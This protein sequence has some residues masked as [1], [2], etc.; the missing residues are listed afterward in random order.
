MARPRKKERKLVSSKPCI[1]SEDGK[2]RIFRCRKSK[3]HCRIAPS[4]SCFVHICPVTFNF[5]SCRE[6]T[7]H[8]FLVSIFHSDA[9]HRLHLLSRNTK[10]IFFDIVSNCF[11]S[12][13]NGI[14]ITSSNKLVVCMSLHLLNLDFQEYLSTMNGLPAL[15]TPSAPQWTSS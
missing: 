12:H 8:S 5:R 2:V 15:R 13:P 14:D 10:G 7:L 9:E 11:L 3:K 4:C 6:E 1:N